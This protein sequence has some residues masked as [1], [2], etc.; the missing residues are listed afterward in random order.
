MK[1]KESGEFFDVQCAIHF[2]KNNKRKF[3]VR[4]EE[5]HTEFF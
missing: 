5:T 1:N 3:S 4:N 2:I